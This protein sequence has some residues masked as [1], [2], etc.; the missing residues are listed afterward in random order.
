MRD[1]ESNNQRVV[2]LEHPAH[3]IV[4]RLRLAALQVGVERGA[5]VRHSLLTENA[6]DFGQ[7]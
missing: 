4:G 6:P 2:R 7:D 3:R 1:F 5:P